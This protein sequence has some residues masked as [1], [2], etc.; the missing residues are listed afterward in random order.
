MADSNKLLSLDVW[1]ASNQ[2][3]RDYINSED[4]KSLKTAA[5]SSDQTKL[6]FYKEANPTSESIPAFEIVIPVS[7]LSSVIQKVTGAVE[8]N[9]VIFGTDGSLKDTGLK[10]TDLPTTATVE[11]MIVEKVSQASHMKKEIVQELP[12][13]ESADQDT[14]Y[15]IKIDS[16]TG[17]DKYE[18]WTKIG[19][20]LVL[21]DD[22]S[23]SLVGYATT[24]QMLE[25]IST[26][27]T[28][29]INEAVAQAD[30]NAQTKADTALSSAKQYTD[31]LVS[32]LTNR[33]AT[34]ETDMTN[35]NQSVTSI[36]NRVTVLENASGGMEVASTE[37]ALA[38]FNSI[39]G[40]A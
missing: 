29:A 9:V 30:V 18:I 19:D 1:G 39:F 11:Q 28:E 31:S 24:E 34:L 2:W 33:V 35:T 12:S 36:S 38:I 5:L 22:T 8:G 13:A 37:E 3:M 32:P 26:A 4:A 7:D 17:T 20:E 16:A 15:L 25:A 21:I 14:F 10:V 23:V 27:K 6:L 40:T